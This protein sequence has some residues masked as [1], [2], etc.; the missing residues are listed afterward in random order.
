MLM[1]SNFIA[2]LFSGLIVLLCIPSI[3]ICEYYGLNESVVHTTQFIATVSCFL[4]CLTYII[5]FQNLSTVSKNVVVYVACLGSGSWIAFLI[6]F[7]ATFDL[8]GID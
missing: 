4:F 8:S 1:K 7:L 5:I 6:Y 2:V 3:Y